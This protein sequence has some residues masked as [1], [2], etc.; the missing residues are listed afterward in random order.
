MKLT[1]EVLREAAQGRI[2]LDRSENPAAFYVMLTALNIWNMGDH[3]I[4]SELRAR[5]RN[6]A[7]VRR[8]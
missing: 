6:L 4:Y 1:E 3:D 2:E 8:Q 7:S 5:E